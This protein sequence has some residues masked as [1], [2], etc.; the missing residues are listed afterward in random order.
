MFNI[1]TSRDNG[2]APIANH[3]KE[4]FNR[5][6][7]DPKTNGQVILQRIDNALDTASRSTIFSVNINVDS[8][9]SVDQT[10][11]YVKECLAHPDWQLKLRKSNIIQIIITHGWDRMPI[12]TRSRFEN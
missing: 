8:P 4:Q 6:Y 2:F 9:A 1:K 12:Y 11:R 7:N 3:I 5:P 10:C